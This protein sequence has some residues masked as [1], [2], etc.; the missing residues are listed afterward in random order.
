MAH[1]FTKCLNCDDVVETELKD[2]DNWPSY[3]KSAS[4]SNHNC[5]TKTKTTITKSASTEKQE[6][7]WA[8]LRRLALLETESPKTE[9]QSQL[10]S[11]ARIHQ[12]R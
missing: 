2:S 12:Y 5:Q 4:T 8:R 10:S 11:W 7:S 1:L 9:S 3:L 6:S